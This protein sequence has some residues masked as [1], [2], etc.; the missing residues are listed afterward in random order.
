MNPRPELLLECLWVNPIEVDPMILLG[1]KLHE[2]KANPDR[3]AKNRSPQSADG[4]LLHILLKR[5]FLSELYL[6]FLN[7]EVFEVARK[8]VNRLFYIQWLKHPVLV[9]WGFHKEE[10]AS[11]EHLLEAAEF[12][13]DR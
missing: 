1:L 11:K 3:F 10:E 9:Q 6:R 12:F 8:F 4:N 2:P 7:R 5:I 13:L